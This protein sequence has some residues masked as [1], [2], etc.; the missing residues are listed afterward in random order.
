M[1]KK[2]LS[3]M[4]ALCL[5][6]ASAALA[7]LSGPDSVLE[8]T[9]WSMIRFIDRLEWYKSGQSSLHDMQGNLLAGPYTRMMSHTNCLTVTIDG[10]LYG[11][12]G[13]IDPDGKV[14]VP[15]EYDKVEA[16]DDWAVAFMFAD[17]TE[18]DYDFSVSAY[19]DGSYV[20]HY[21]T[22][23][24]TALYYLP[25]AALVASLEGRTYANIRANGSNCNIQTRDGAV[26]AYTP[27][28]AMSDVSIDWVSDFS[29]LPAVPTP[30]YKLD[31][32]AWLYQLVDAAGNPMTEPLYSSVR[33]DNGWFV[34]SDEDDME[35]L[36]DLAGNEVVPTEFSEVLEIRVGRAQGYETCGIFAA[37]TDDALYLIQDGQCTEFEKEGVAEYTF[38]GTCLMLQ[39]EDGSLK[40]AFPDG[41]V[42]SFP[43]NLSWIDPYVLP[44]GVYIVVSEAD[45]DQLYHL[46]DDH[47][48][49]VLTSPHA[50]YVSEMGSVITAADVDDATLVY[51]LK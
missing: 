37:E 17:G 9:R 8:G 23:A 15:C 6:T 50:I 32:D 12:Q 51:S 26:T 3:L 5:L 47:A 36:A 49:A 19:I 39:M 38:L 29:Y 40:T 4:L 20:N 35:G 10:G 48:N 16:Y 28:G 7:E 34:V 21:H 1:L 33:M 25:D 43:G 11:L 2:I 44:Q 14:L 31:E 22:I 41:S 30:S 18:E 27:Q 46:Y 13:L 45:G 42:C 24:S